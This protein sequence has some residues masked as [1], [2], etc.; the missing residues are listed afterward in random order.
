MTSN[1]RIYGYLR[2][3]TKEQDALRAKNQL[4][5]FAKQSNLKISSF[6]VENESGATLNRPEL[7]RLLEIAQPGDIIL[8]EQI[9]RISRLNDKDWNKLKTI[10]KAKELRIVSLDLPTSH[11]LM[12]YSDEF[13]NRMLSAI[14]D[15]MLDM[16]AAVARKDYQDRKRRQKDGMIK[17]IGQGKY[18]G[19][20]ENKELQE[21]IELLLN[22]GKSYTMIVRLLGCSRGTIAKVSTRVKDELTALSIS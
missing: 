6:F 22:E 11:Q 17:A 16:L 7:F 8:V 9:D 2:A 19:R 1:Y 21:K 3:S 5:E 15:L 12:Q 10:I 20:R 13:T 14:N 18:L 4:V